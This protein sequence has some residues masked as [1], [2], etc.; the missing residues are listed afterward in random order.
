VRWRTDAGRV[1]PTFIVQAL[2]NEPITI[3]RDG[4]QARSFGYVDDMI[5]TFV[6]L[7]TAPARFRTALPSA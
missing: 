3:Y 5:T 4:S 2:Y 1:V 7:M 6:A